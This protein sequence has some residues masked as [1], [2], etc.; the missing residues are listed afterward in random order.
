MIEDGWVR[1]LGMGWGKEEEKHRQK[2]KPPKHKTQTTKTHKEQA[3]KYR[4]ICE[5][6]DRYILTHVPTRTRTHRV[7]CRGREDRG[8]IR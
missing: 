7:D 4:Y 3:Y 5:C 6:P 1:D 8:R 2:D